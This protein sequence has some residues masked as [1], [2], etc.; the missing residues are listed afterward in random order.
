MSDLKLQKKLAAKA[1]GVGIARIKFDTTQLDDIKEAITKADIRGLIEG[2]SIKALPARGTS[3]HRARKRHI[4]RTKGRQRGAG[5][6]E[7][8]AGARTPKK[9][10]WVR[11]I[12]LQREILKKLRDKEKLTPGIYRGLYL[13]AKGGF[14]RSRKHLLLYLTQNDIL[15]E[16]KK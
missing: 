2:G 16:A 4:Q 7:G 12:R 1:A 8:K 15:K 14:F 13:K 6:R 11:R 10:M 9:R 3:R 5:H